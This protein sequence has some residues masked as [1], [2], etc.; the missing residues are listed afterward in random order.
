M[1][2]RKS[3]AGIGMRTTRPRPPRIP[4]GRIRERKR[5]YEEE[6]SI[7]T[8]IL[9]DPLSAGFAMKLVRVIGPING[10]SE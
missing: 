7:F 4:K 10:D 5:F 8:P 3:G 2:M 9:A 1:V 6:L